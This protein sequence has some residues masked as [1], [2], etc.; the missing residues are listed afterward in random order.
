VDR[1]DGS[2]DLE[3]SGLYG[4]RIKEAMLFQEGLDKLKLEN[5]MSQLKQEK[6]ESERFPL[7]F[8]DAKKDK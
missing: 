5:Q 2:V 8:F 1:R 7:Q 4:R 3:R 6:P